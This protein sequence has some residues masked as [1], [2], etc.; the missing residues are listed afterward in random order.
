MKTSLK[1]TDENDKCYGVT[2]MAIGIVALDSE[3]L[4]D[5]LSL[6]TDSG[7]SVKFT[8]EYYFSGN[9]RLSAKIA[10]NEILRHFQLS[11]AMMISNVM[12]RHYVSRHATISDDIRKAMMEIATAE[13]RDTCS[14]DDD[15]INGMFVKSYNYLHRLFNHTGVQAVANDF[16]RT[17]SARRSLT[18]SEVVEELRA[19]AML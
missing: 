7:D 4:L 9:P 3:E 2:G 18:R 8:S 13:G 16:A 10:W 5:S 14:L 19:L 6:D 1:Y 12:C 17:L 11:I 15:E